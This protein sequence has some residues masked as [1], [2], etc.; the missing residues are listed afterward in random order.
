L[1]TPLVID[2][3]RIS[4]VPVQDLQW[5]YCQ[6]GALLDILCGGIRLECRGAA[7]CQVN[8]IAPGFIADTGATGRVPEETLRE[9]AAQLPVA[10]PG[11]VKDVAAAA[12]FLASPDAGFITSEL[13]NVNGGRHFGS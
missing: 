9:I 8:T 10:R 1:S 5:S 7:V 12:L 4:R 13:L 2:R 3:Y 11:H 6:R